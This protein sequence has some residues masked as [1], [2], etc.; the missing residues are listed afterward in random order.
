MLVDKPLSLR[1]VVGIAGLAG[2][3]QDGYGWGSGPR[4]DGVRLPDYSL[5]P[6]IAKIFAPI[7][8]RPGKFLF[9][10]GAEIYLLFDQ[11][12]RTSAAANCVNP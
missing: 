1:P 11:A 3:G 6:T 9:Q 4:N 12:E 2:F 8:R 10:G 7:A 5:V